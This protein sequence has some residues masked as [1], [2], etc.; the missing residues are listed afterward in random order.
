MNTSKQWRKLDYIITLFFLFSFVKAE[1]VEINLKNNDFSET[2]HNQNEVLQ[3]RILGISSPYIKISVEGK[4]NKINNHIISYYQKEDLK[5]RKQL[6]QSLKDKTIMWLTQEQIKNDFYITVECAKKPCSF[7][8]NINKK[9]KAELYLNEQYTYYVAEENKEMDFILKDS[10]KEY[11]E[12]RRYYVAI[13]VRG[14][15]E[16]ESKLSGGEKEDFSSTRYS[17]YRVEY[18]DDFINSKFILNIKGEVGDLINV[19]LIFFSEDIDNHYEA[20]LKLENGEEVSG[21]LSNKLGHIFPYNNLD[22]NL[23]PNGYFYDINNKHINGAFNKDFQYYKIEANNDDIF[24]TLQ[25]IF[26]TEYD[27]QGN[28]KY[29]PLLNGIYNY[30]NIYEGTTIGLI[31]MKPEYDFNFLTYEIIPY[32]GDI[33]ASIYECN[34]YPL[35]HINDEIIKKSK[36]IEKYMNYYYTFNNNEWEEDINPISKKQNMLLITCKKGLNIPNDR[37]LCSA[38]INMKTDKKFVNY[39]DFTK[40]KPPYHRFIRQNNEDKY[41][42]QNSDNEIQLYIEEITGN[43]SIEINGKKNNYQKYIE[44]NKYFYVIPNSIDANIIIKANE[45]SFYSMNGNFNNKKEIF[46]IGYNYLMSIN[47]NIQLSFY[48][49]EEDEVDNVRNSK[50]I[51]FEKE[52]PHEFKSLLNY[53]NKFIEDNDKDNTLDSYVGFYPLNCDIFVKIMWLNHTIMFNVQKEKFRKEIFVDFY[54]YKFEISKQ[55]NGNPSESCL[56]YISSYLKNNNNNYGIILLNNTSQIIKEEKKLIPFSFPH[57]NLENNININFELL[58]EAEYKVRISINDSIVQNELIN[59]KKTNIILVSDDIKK[60]CIDFKFICNI[61]LEVERENNQK[62]SN[63]KINLTSLKGDK[64]KGDGENEKETEEEGK[65]NGKNN[66]KGN[67]EEDDDDDDNNNKL[68]I[69]LSILG[70]G[71]VL[72]II[73]AIIFYLKVYNK[74]KDLNNAINQISFKDDDDREGMGDTLLS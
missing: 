45:N 35:C 22:P 65:N 59:S 48:E 16:I 74:N 34:N 71:V 20:K 6:S 70:V 44:G 53:E 30:K 50:Y 4:D 38:Y 29:S 18:N 57:T 62:E 21:F 37:S 26:E 64:N 32:L 15:Y 42:L 25:H 17:Y 2:Y 9:D 47:N 27:G 39:T 72:I 36:K 55:N 8:I 12:E 11:D 60:N 68:I 66:G 58:N 31:P 3:F 5:E 40:E 1:F 73:G 69:I 67:G 10:Q 49:D 23:N 43:I 24:Y 19:G 41:F 51:A 13:W 33:D 54:N 14:N 46:T 63:F 56:F 7:D 52:I 28:N 61:F